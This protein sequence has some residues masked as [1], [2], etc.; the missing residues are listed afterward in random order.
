MSS[1]AKVSVVVVAWNS[2][3]DIEACVQSLLNQT[4]A[5]YEI[6]LVDNASTDG[7]AGFVAEHFPGVHLIRLDYNAGF[8]KGNNIGIART[9]GDWVLALNPDAMLESDWIRKLIEFADE[10][11]RAGSI[12]GLLLR[13]GAVPGKEIID[14]VGIEIYRSRRVRDRG[15]GE[16]ATDLPAESSRVFGVCAAAA[17]YRREMLQDVV[18]SGEVF[19]E[20]F[21]CYYEDADLAW[22]AWRRGWEAW[23]VPQAI[24]RHKRGGSPIGA[25]FS[26]YLTHRNRLWL[27]IRNDRFGSLWSALP[28]LFFHEILVFLRMLRYPYLFKAS[29]EAVA[30]LSNAF[31]ERK[32]IRSTVKIPPP[33]LP[34]IGFSS[35][36][37]RN[38]LRSVRKF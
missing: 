30:G 36:E 15:A 4:C 20:S 17:L 38:A 14:S 11:P 27:I 28:E 13:T 5:P 12:G 22:R 21:F 29:I 2:T 24:G 35:L 31:R 6:I 32:L 25:K 1:N 18:V 34:G 16:S 7:T 8:A 3:R 26:R 33:Y 19:P 10:H 9:T 23:I 37:T